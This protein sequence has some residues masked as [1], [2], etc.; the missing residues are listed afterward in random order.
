MS[1]Y[2]F[3]LIILALVLILYFFPRGDDSGEIKA[4]FDEVIEAAGNRDYEGITGHFSVQYKDE[5]GAGYPVVKNIIIKVFEKY[6][7]VEASYS[8]LSVVIN[9]NEYGEKEAAANMDVEVTGYKSGIPD[10]LIGNS[11]SPDNITVTLR[12]SGLGGWKITRVE[13]LDDRDDY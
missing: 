12:K 7:S 5:Y 1:R 9:K 10:K 6:D 11:E 2:I 3:L 4:L 13:G 8:G